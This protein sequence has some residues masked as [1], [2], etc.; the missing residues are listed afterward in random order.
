MCEATYELSE[1]TEDE[2]KTDKRT[3]E[4]FF[5][6]LTSTPKFAWMKSAWMKKL[7]SFPLTLIHFSKQEESLFPSFSLF[8][9]FA[10]LVCLHLF[11]QKAFEVMT[12]DRKL[13]PFKPLTPRGWV[14][15]QSHS[16]P[17]S[18]LSFISSSTWLFVF[19]SCNISPLSLFFT[20]CLKGMRGNVGDTD[21]EN[22]CTP[23]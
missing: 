13:L 15:F 3:F 6:F 12:H 16:T 22:W 2:R 8:K 10:W 19:W 23:S 20:W 21:N 11:S 1:H 17:S 18:S 5:I 9:S 7:K 14:S 4:E